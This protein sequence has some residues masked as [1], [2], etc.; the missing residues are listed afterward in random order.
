MDEEFQV[1]GTLIWYYYICKRQVWLMAHALNPDPDDENIQQGRNIHE[2]SYPRDKQEL[3]LGHVK[4][5][6]VRSERGQLVIGEIKKSSRF[7]SSATRQLQYYLWQ[8]E[9]MGLKAQGEL[10]IPEERK[11]I[12]VVLDDEAKKE[13][14]RAQEDIEQIVGQPLPPPTQKIQLCK[15]CAYAEF[16]WA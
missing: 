8:L 12:E 15:P 7:V 6:L 4:I 16:C 11:R 1:N 13:L 10:F 2:Y 3:N 9:Q 5:D 14:L